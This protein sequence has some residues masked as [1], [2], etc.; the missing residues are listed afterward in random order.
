MREAEDELYVVM[1]LM[2]S[3]LHRII[4]SGQQ[5]TDAHFKHFMFQL[6]RGL[7]FTHKHGVL[8]RDLKPGNILVTKACDLRVRST[9][10]NQQ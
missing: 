6:L 1:E 4:Q 3:D 2:D 9:F 7:N 5:L 10:R 8:H